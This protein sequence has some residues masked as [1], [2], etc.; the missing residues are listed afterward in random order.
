MTRSTELLWTETFQKRLLKTLYYNN[1]DTKKVKVFQKL[2][3][4]EILQQTFQIYISWPNLMDGRNPYSQKCFTDWFIKC[5]DGC[6]FLSCMNLSIFLP[7][8]PAIYRIGNAPNILCPRCKEQDESHPPSPL[9]SS[10]LHFTFYCKISEIN[11][12]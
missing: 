5:Y 10:L 1:K 6:I 7:L 11:L 9:L 4:N 2:L 3:N 8:N 12:D